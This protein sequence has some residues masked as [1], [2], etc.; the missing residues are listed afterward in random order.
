MKIG[1]TFKMVALIFAD[2]TQLCCALLATSQEGQRKRA[3]KMEVESWSIITH[4][5]TSNWVSV[6][7]DASSASSFVIRSTRSRCPF[8][9][10]IVKKWDHG[11]FNRVVG[12]PSD[13]V[14]V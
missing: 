11:S 3:M 7:N 12:M 8:I 14:R 1:R 9:I 2:S 6:I 13:A 10:T 5:V 4:F